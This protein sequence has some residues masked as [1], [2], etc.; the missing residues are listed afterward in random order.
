MRV[1]RLLGQ[2]VWLVDSGQ[3]VQ[4]LIL[5][6][7]A[8]QTHR[9]RCHHV[10]RSSSARVVAAR[11]EEGVTAVAGRAVASRRRGAACW[12]RRRRLGTQV[13]VRQHPLVTAMLRRA[14]QER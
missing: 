5:L 4:T 13:H 14:E 6:S 3:A 7:R 1:N 11:A 8:L 10:T 9:S 12:P 2:K